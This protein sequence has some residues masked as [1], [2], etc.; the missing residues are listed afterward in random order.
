MIKND[1]IK[2]YENIVIFGAGA[3]KFLYNYM[4]QEFADR[5][6]I[7]ID[8]DEKKWGQIAYGLKICSPECLSELNKERT[9]IISCLNKRYNDEIEEQMHKLRWDK[10][11]YIANR[12]MERVNSYEFYLNRQ[13]VSSKN[14]TPLLAIIEL[15]GVC[16]LK[17]VYCPF[18]GALDGKAGQKGLMTWETLRAVTAQIK[19]ITSINNLDV[20]GN[21]ETFV[22]PEWFE[23]TQYVLNETHIPTVRMFTNG[24]LLDEDNIKKL[25]S[26]NAEL[27]ELYVSIDGRTPEDNDKYR[28]GSKYKTIKNNI[29]LLRKLKAESSI[30]VQVTIRNCYPLRENEIVDIPDLGMKAE[31]PDYIKKDFPDM[32]STSI[33]T[34]IPKSNSGIFGVD[35]LKQARAEFSDEYPRCA[36]PFW[37]ICINNRG[38]LSRC[39]N[40]RASADRIA[41]S[42][43]E[44]DL[45]DLWYNDEQMNIARKQLIDGENGSAFCY[46][47]IQR[48]MGEYYLMIE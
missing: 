1:E 43:L 5:I 11:F 39:L 40:A 34:W 35:G 25:L 9:V 47:C 32:E 33:N 22:H 42:I 44:R 20:S 48:G 19:K 45:L 23:M 37:V 12:D 13:G 38:E 6:S 41:G 46:E 27:I 2:K 17:C 36:N 26:L 29:D 3:D 24:M 4:I 21:G 10:N 7:I 16:N 28:V 8:N 30:E 31:V 18:H 14:Y 15:S